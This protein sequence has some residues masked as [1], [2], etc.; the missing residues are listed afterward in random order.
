MNPRAAAGREEF[1]R[2]HCLPA[3]LA[4]AAHADLTGDDRPEWTNLWRRAVRPGPAADPEHVRITFDRGV[5][6]A[7][8]GETHTLGE[9][10]RELNRRA[11]GHGI[12]RADGFESPA[13]TT[14]VAAHQ[15][16]ERLTLSWSFLRAK[17]EAER[18]WAES[19]PEGRAALDEHIRSTQEHVSGEVRVLLSDGRAV[20]TERRSDRDSL[21]QSLA[22][23]LAQL[24][25]LPSKIAAN[26]DLQNQ[27]TGA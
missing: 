2:R 14:L 9:L 19:A 21:G 13:A 16:L 17:R 22:K 26:R 15:A 3:L 8:D 4:N 1:A 27:W 24:W 20:V 10:L 6:V 25:S 12:G 18:R 11:G 7:L 5:P 23:G